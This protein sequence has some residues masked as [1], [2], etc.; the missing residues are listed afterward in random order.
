MGSFHMELNTTFNL[1]PRNW[2]KL[3]HSGPVGETLFCS[4]L[5]IE[6]LYCHCA[7]EVVVPF[8]FARQSK[9]QYPPPSPQHT[10]KPDPIQFFMRHEILSPLACCV[11]LLC[12][13]LNPITLSCRGFKEND[14][15]FV[16]AYCD[17]ST[18]EISLF[19]RAPR[20]SS[21]HFPVHV[22]MYS[23]IIEYINIYV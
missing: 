3:K 21:F 22:F 13:Y 19:I 14:T 1:F 18:F 15:H 8:V 17:E 12:T 9:C 10:L 5:F 11:C 7:T 20:C 16:K 23:N 2:I 6:T 4:F